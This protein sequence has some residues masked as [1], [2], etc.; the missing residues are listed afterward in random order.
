MKEHTLRRVYG[1]FLVIFAI[2]AVI[3]A[4]ALRSL[5]RSVAS[6]DWVNHANAVIYEAE[7][8]FSSLQ[9]AEGALRTYLLTGDVRDRTSSSEA[10]ALLDEHL[11]TLKALTRNEAAAQAHVERIESLLRAR[12]GFAERVETARAAS[13]TASVQALLGEDAGSTAVGEI[14]REIERLVALQATLLT[15]RDRQAFLQASTTRWVVGT[16]VSVNLV[17]F[18]V[19]AWI[20]RD[21]LQ[22]RKKL[23]ATLQASNEL[24]E[25]K[26]K[27]RT[28][29]LA[30]TN[31]Q[32]V[33]ENRERRWAN[34]AL[35]H[36]LRYNQLIVDSV[37][38]LVFV[39]T[40]ALKVTRVN[41]AALRVSGREQAELL[42]R[43]LNTVLR[44][45][46]TTPLDSFGANDPVAASLRDGRE[47]RGHP[48]EL[49]ARDGRAIAVILSCVPLRDRDK[50]VG[51]VITLQLTPASST[52]SAA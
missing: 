10:Y 42:G 34:Q 12:I 41:P 48:A 28:A 38:D 1:L 20:I 36:Q 2:L 11:E 39:L 35:E 23:A 40:R 27:E 49:L 5:N 13:Q 16:G 22:T 15:E 25:V 19:V 47:L 51:G 32:L 44:W 6:T 18:G 46:A 24:L 43:S 8:T 3:A 4:Y 37:H 21:D 31:S 52:P 30:A 29:E 45:N 17:L 9:A 14:S 26:V 7:G 33:A 50:V